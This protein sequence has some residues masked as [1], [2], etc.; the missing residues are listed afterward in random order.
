MKNVLTYIISIM[1]ILLLMMLLLFLISSKSLLDRE[2]SSSFECGFDPLESSRIPFSSHFFLIAVVFLIFD[3]ELVIIMPMMF[4]INM[5][6]MIDLYMI[7][8]SFLIIL[9]LGLYH[10]W[11]NKMLDWM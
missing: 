3:V 2:K 7:M 6:N 10:E 8:S 4:S 5:V 11:Y 9:I 1:V